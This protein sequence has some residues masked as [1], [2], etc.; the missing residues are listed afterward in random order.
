MDC[1]VNDSSVRQQF[2]C[3]EE[4]LGVLK[5][6]YGLS[7]SGNVKV[8]IPH[9]IPHLTPIA[10]VRFVD[11][12][13]GLADYDE[14]RLLKI[15]FSKGGPFC[16]D[17]DVNENPRLTYS[18]RG[19]DVTNQVIADVARINCHGGNSCMFSFARGGFPAG[20]LTV[21]GNANILHDV[22]NYDVAENVLLSPRLHERDIE[23]WAEFLPFLQRKFPSVDFLEGCVDAISR[24][25]F[26]IML[27]G[28]FHDLLSVVVQLQK[29]MDD[30]DSDAYHDIYA[31]HFARDG[32][33][34]DESKTNKR[35]FKKDM[36]F[37]HQF[38]PFHGKMLPPF[39]M[40]FRWPLEKDV[41]PIVAYL[42]PK[43]TKT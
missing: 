30:E 20:T 21:V 16:A 38:F 15:W 33:F 41:R 36:T 27:V 37:H 4:V 11:I 29:A 19:A 39:R 3:K 7:R 35:K 2:L 1:L 6:L 31:K 18:F 28:K 43:L 32:W 24:S 23:T 42:G 9:V 22:D 26:D 40:H 14:K 5:E 17:L 10:G 25:P 34:S 12:I 8:Y 13:S